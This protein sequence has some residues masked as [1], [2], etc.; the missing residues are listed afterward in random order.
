MTFAQIF[1]PNCSLDELTFVLKFYE[2]S[3]FEQK[4]ADCMK[5]T[6]SDTLVSKY[7]CIL[8]KDFKNISYF[9][10]TLNACCYL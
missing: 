6:D 4:L 10:L 8:S 9:E 5:G 3:E 7:N 1:A 2:R